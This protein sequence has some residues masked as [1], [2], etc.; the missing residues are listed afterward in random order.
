[1]ES[2]R[3]PQESGFLTSITAGSAG[4][5]AIAIKLQFVIL[6][7]CR[8]HHSGPDLGKGLLEEIWK[9]SH[10]LLHHDRHHLHEFFPAGRAV[11]SMSNAIASASS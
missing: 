11:D 9:V 2:G 10:Q 7:R 6:V 1:L 5:G 4:S 3:F 8:L